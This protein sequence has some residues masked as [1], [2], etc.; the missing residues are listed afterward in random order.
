MQKK[1]EIKAKFDLHHIV[2]GMK[3]I[4]PQETRYWEL[5]RR[6]VFELARDYS[7]QYIETPIVEQQNLFVRS[8][9]ESTDIVEKEMF[10]FTDQGGEA[11]VLR[12]E[13]TASI[14][15]AFNEHGMIN[16]PQPVKLFYYGSMFRRER[17]QAG[18]QREFHQF[19]F[20]T[21]GDSQAITDAQLIL[22]A[23]N[24]F[25]ELGLSIDIQIN[26][27]GNSQSRERYKKEL[28]EYYKPKRNQL[29]DDCKKR[30]LKNPLRVLD[31]KNPNCVELSLDAPQIID[32]LDEED[33]KHFTQVLEYLDELE[34]PYNL[35]PR[36]IRGLDYYSRTTFEIWP[37]GKSEGRQNALGGGGRYD[38]LSEL[39]G[40][41]P[42]PACGFAVGIERTISLLKEKEIFVPGLETPQ[43]Y[44]AQLGDVSRKKALKLYENLRRE[45]FTVA[46]SFAKDGIK[47]QLEI[48]NRLN[49]KIALILGQKENI[50]GTILMRDMESGTQEVINYEK[51][52]PEL[53]KRLSKVNQNNGVKIIRTDISNEEI[54][55]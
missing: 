50:D 52:I 53:R 8:I 18:R 17:P 1:V 11:L 26:S 23:Y 33:N 49:I 30:L 13:A 35:N 4:L 22:L 37:S 44:L 29:C 47:P 28:A 39:L 9:G 55:L 46:E 42:T 38:G 54:K 34:L 2:R 40:G 36:I 27:L 12:P 31:C 5:I 25:K 41:R 32:Y 14:V 6:K 24:F 16:Q 7:F 19:G 3:D 15:R 20:E 45:G 10:T 21:L 51:I 48:A 43:V